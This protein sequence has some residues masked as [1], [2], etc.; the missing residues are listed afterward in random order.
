MS[1]VIRIAGPYDLL[2]Q[3][4]TASELPFVESVKSKRERLDSQNTSAETTYN[5]TVSTA[6]GDSVPQQIRDVREF[7]ARNGCKITAILAVATGVTGV[8]DFSWDFPRDAVGQYNR[9]PADLLAELAKLRLDLEVSV[10]GYDG[11]QTP[12]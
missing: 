6:S 11:D 7:L 3:A 10:Y 2:A 9:F 1:T 8:V 5:L 12:R 4:I